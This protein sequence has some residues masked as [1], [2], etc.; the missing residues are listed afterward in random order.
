MAMQFRSTDDLTWSIKY[1]NGSEG[2]YNVGGAVTY[3][4][5]Y[6]TFSGTSGTSNGTVGSATGF[7][8]P[9][10]VLIIQSQFNSYGGW[11][12][13][14]I[15]AISGTT[16]TLLNPLRQNYGSTGQIYVLNQWRQVNLSSGATLYAPAWNGTSGGI[17]P[18]MASDYIAM[19]SG[20]SMNATGR[21]YRG[22]INGPEQQAGG[23]GESY[24]NA[25]TTRQT[26]QLNG[27]GGGGRASRGFDAGHAGGGG[28][29]ATAGQNGTGHNDGTDGEGGTTYGVTDLSSIYMGAGGGGNGM[30]TGLVPVDGSPGGGIIML[31][32]PTISISGTLTAQGNNASSTDYANGG[33]GAGGSVLLKG[34][35]VS[36]NSINVEGG[37]QSPSTGWGARGGAGGRGRIAV[38]YKTSQSVTTAN[39]AT[40]TTVQDNV[41]AR[42]SYAVLGGMA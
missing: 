27:G 36:V 29:H 10:I 38:Y 6:S 16:F 33:A 4:V 24:N 20:S 17:L 18:I 1:G 23:A 8:A 30:D 25:N 41:L 42:P 7:N 2:V 19:S 34:D 14:V 31:F 22:G 37:T 11:E 15:T 35:A 5:V 9:Q 26:S 3:P 32:A 21:G 12:L 13:N 40:V 39:G 28:G